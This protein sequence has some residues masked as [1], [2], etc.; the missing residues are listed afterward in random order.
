[1][2]VFEYGSRETHYLARKDAALAAVMKEIGHVYREVTPDLFAALVQQIV[3]QQ[4]STKGAMTIWNRMLAAFGSLTPQSLTPQSLALA[5]IEDIQ[6]CGMSMR[7]AGYIKELTQTV[8]DGRLDLNALRT[9]PDDELCAHLVQIKG[10]GVW[11]AEM[12]MTFSMQRPDVMS[13]DDIA[14]H[15]GLRMLYRHRKISR[16]LFARYKKR[17]SP[18]ASVASLYLWEI[19]GG[20]CKGLVDPAPLSEAQ[21][22]AR[23]K[24]RGKDKAKRASPGSPGPERGSRA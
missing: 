7:K 20:G 4:I 6:K 22:R 24:K 12:L 8:Q 5:P 10:I 19:A 18:Y 14:I 2:Q 3:C 16:E 9:M 15:R 17:Y 13:W 1:M 21:K 23:A 11:T